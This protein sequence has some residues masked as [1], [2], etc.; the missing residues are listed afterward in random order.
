MQFTSN[1]F[2]YKQFLQKIWLETLRSFHDNV[3]A[4]TPCQASKAF[5]HQTPR[6]IILNHSR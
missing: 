1:C 3:L 4:K 5:L 2:F 6:A